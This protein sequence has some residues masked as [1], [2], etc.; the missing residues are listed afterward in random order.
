LAKIFSSIRADIDIREAG[1]CKN[2]EVIC[3]L[4]RKDKREMSRKLDSETEVDSYKQ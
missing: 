4:T 3:M 1:E 2:E